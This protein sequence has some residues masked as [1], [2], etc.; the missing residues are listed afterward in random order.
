MADER[1]IDYGQTAYDAYVDRSGGKSL[2]SDEDLPEWRDLQA[3]IRAAWS[4][5]AVAVVRRCR[6]QSRNGW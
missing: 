3:D 6:K 1:T 4:A 2:I 5:A